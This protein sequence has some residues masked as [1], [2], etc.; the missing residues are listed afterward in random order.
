[1]NK[2]SRLNAYLAWPILAISAAFGGS[3]AAHEKIWSSDQNPIKDQSKGM[4]VAPHSI[5]AELDQ[6]LAL[7]K[8]AV[9]LSEK[10]QMRIMTHLGS[11][12]GDKAEIIIIKAEKEIGIYV[13]K[14]L[15]HLGLRDGRQLELPQGFQMNLQGVSSEGKVLTS[16]PSPVEISEIV[17]VFYASFPGTD[18][19][20]LEEI[21]ALKE[22]RRTAL[23]DVSQ[24]AQSLIEDQQTQKERSRELEAANILEKQEAAALRRQKILDRSFSR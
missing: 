15:A 14:G 3:L 12:R 22:K 23:A 6:D 4:T 9:V 20:F 24:L 16:V 8:G 17:K 7:L 21:A 18:A 19:G 10:S 5:I 11:I 13:L 1:M 2:T